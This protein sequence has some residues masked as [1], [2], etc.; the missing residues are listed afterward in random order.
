MHHSSLARMHWNQDV[1]NPSTAR[2]QR[3]RSVTPES[4]GMP[5]D[6]EASAQAVL[7]PARQRAV[8]P[9]QRPRLAVRF[10]GQIQRPHFV[11]P[12][13]NSRN[14]RVK[15]RRV[16]SLTRQGAPRYERRKTNNSRPRIDLIV[17]RASSRRSMAGAKLV[18]HVAG[19]Y[20]CRNQG[21]QQLAS[22]LR[23]AVII[24]TPRDSFDHQ[25]RVAF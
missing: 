8:P 24:Q 11:E 6:F 23:G 5:I 19:T 2:D 1:L 22:R 10:D 16:A 21:F 15:G 9:G 14:P 3:K 12:R 18:P 7:F 25:N 4:D 13:I 17:S 20:P